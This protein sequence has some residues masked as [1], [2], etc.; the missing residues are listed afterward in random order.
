MGLYTEDINNTAV[1]D[2]A[3]ASGT[4]VEVI[5]LIPLSQDFNYTII[6][7]PNYFV[8]GSTGRARLVVD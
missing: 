4:P 6:L 8:S 1:M 5:Y 3:L 7:N 2:N